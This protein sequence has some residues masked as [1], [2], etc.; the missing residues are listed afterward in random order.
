MSWTEKKIQEVSKS[1][2]EKVIA[3]SAFRQRCKTDINSVI[4]ELSGL[5]VPNSF[6]INVVDLDDADLTIALPKSQ[7]D[8]LSDSDLESVAGGKSTGET[9]AIAGAITFEVAAGGLPFVLV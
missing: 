2:S 9:V 5:Q 7:T 8:E 6:K 3:D 4:E 1:I